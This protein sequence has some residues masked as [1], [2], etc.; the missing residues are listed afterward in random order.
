M[1]SHFSPSTLFFFGFQPSWVLSLCSESFG[2]PTNSPPAWHHW[3]FFALEICSLLL[4]PFFYF[5][6]C[7]LTSNLFLATSEESLSAFERAFECLPPPNTES[8]CSLGQ[9]LQ[10]NKRNRKN[11]NKKEIS[12]VCHRLWNTVVDLRASAAWKEK[13]NNQFFHKNSKFQQ[14]NINKTIF[15][16]SMVCLS[17]GLR[18]AAADP[19]LGVGARFDDGGGARFEGGGAR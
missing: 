1:N 6:M 17:T 19:L 2:F 13:I 8:P 10:Q 3:S 15:R 9:Y 5:P 11:F 4:D 16:I 18:F 14:T 7:S 12:Y